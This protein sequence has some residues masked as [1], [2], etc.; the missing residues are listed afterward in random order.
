MYIHQMF[1]HLNIFLTFFFILHGNKQGS[2]KKDHS[3]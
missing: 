3:H 1:I 2:G